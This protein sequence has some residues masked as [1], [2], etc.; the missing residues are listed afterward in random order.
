MLRALSRLALAGGVL[1]AFAAPLSADPVLYVSN[2]NGVI[3]RYTLSGGSL[4]TFTTV[5]GQTT[6]LAA[7]EQVLYVADYSNH[8][9]RPFA[10]NGTPLATLAP[11]TGPTGLA[12]DAS[13]NLFV[14]NQI[15]GNIRKFAPDGTDL[16]NFVAG[17]S[18]PWGLAFD[19]SG[20]LYV[21][22]RGASQ[23]RKYA[24]DGTPLGVFA[25]TGMNQP[26]G[27]AFDALGNLLVANFGDSTIRKFSPSGA[28][29]GVFAS[30][31]VNRPT[32]IVFDDDDN[33]YVAN[34]GSSS[35]RVFAANG[36]DLGDVVTGLALPQGITI[37]RDPPS[38]VSNL[39][40]SALKGKAVAGAGLS[41]SAKDTTSNN[42]EANA[43]ASQTWFYLSTNP[44]KDAGDV[45]LAPATG[46]SVA[47]LAP[48]ETSTGTT[49]VTLPTDTANG[50]RFLLACADGPGA[51]AESNEGDNCKSKTLYVGP[52]LKVAKLTAPVSAIPGQ[53]IAVADTTQNAGGAPTAVVTTTRLYLS[54]D[55]KLDASDV[56]LSPGRSVAILAAGTK[57]ADT[58][59]VTIPANTTPGA[60][61]IL[62]KADDG[63]VQAES[64]ETNN[65]KFVPLTV[66]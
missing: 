25:S 29:L 18:M 2:S 40:V 45:Q 7:R 55:K 14:S 41:Y 43:S 21:A 36:T 32:E 66:N 51:I 6:G 42:G 57:S 56:P 52:D 17:L 46:R 15:G 44:V 62:A 63:G 53:T 5:A 50:K 49:A 12:F 38:A 34:W 48:G 58:T 9:V 31:G 24:A 28:D 3:S 37:M 1:T 60:Y 26:I 59:N 4:G 10:A 22:E 65:V 20:H 8:L 27:I 23:V 13:G 19:A 30:S 11:G 47:P 61:Y 16:G 54:V 39:Q 64:K 33:L 35:V